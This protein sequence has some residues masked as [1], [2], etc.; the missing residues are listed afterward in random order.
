MTYGAWASGFAFSWSAAVVF[1]EDLLLLE[2]LAVICT[3][4]VVN[5]SV[6]NRFSG[7]PSSLPD[8]LR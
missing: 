2:G 8:W 3:Y 4:S 1:L 7:R 5:V 6:C